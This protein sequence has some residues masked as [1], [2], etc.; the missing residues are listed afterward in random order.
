MSSVDFCTSSIRPS[1]EL[2]ASSAR[3]IALAYRRSIFSRTS[4]SDGVLPGAAS[5]DIDSSDRATVSC[6]LACS[7]WLSSLVR[8]AI[9]CWSRWALFST[10]L[11]AWVAAFSAWSCRTFRSSMFCSL[12]TSW[13][14]KVCAVVSYRTDSSSLPPARDLSARTSACRA[15][16]CNFCTLSISRDSFISSWRWFPITA[17]ACWTSAWCCRWASSIACWICTFGS[18]YSSILAPNSA[19]RYRQP[20]TNGFAICLGPFCGQSSV[21]SSHGGRRMRAVAT[22][23]CDGLPT[24]RRRYAHADGSGRGQDVAAPVAAGQPAGGPQRGGQ[25]AVLADRH[26]DVAVDHGRHRPL[27]D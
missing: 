1:T 2:E 14:A 27:R 22:P 20:L 10:A 5:E 19:I 24:H 15:E 6:I 8:S 21:G 26:G 13:V 12:E 7:S 11:R 25:R 23:S 16:D 17:A 18:A 9:F 3:P 4:S